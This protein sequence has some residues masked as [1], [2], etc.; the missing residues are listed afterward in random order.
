MAYRLLLRLSLFC[1]SLVQVLCSST[2]TVLSSVFLFFLF[3]ID[4]IAPTFALPVFFSLPVSAAI[5]IHQKKIALFLHQVN[6]P[7]LFFFFALCFCWSVLWENLQL[8]PFIFSISLCCKITLLCLWLNLLIH[9]MMRTRVRCVYFIEA[10]V[11]FALLR[12]ICL[13]F[14]RNNINIENAF[15]PSASR[16]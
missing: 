10:E 13:P 15:A 12:R 8:S 11:V 5:G 2:G 16:T 6:Y 4:I 14:N 9:S 3:L 7:W 1:R